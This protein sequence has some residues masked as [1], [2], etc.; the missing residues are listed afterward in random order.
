MFQSPYQSITSLFRSREIE[1]GITVQL[2]HGDEMVESGNESP[3]PTNPQA[4]TVLKKMPRRSRPE[5]I[6]PAAFAGFLEIVPFPQVALPA[7]FCHQCAK[8]SGSDSGTKNIPFSRSENQS[9]QSVTRFTVR[10]GGP[11]L[12]DFTGG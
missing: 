11:V 12:D 5:L 6:L 9:G 3:L 10:F 2:E 1:I 4:K 7:V 8:I